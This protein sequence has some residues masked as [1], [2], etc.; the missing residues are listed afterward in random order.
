MSVINEINNNHSVI[1]DMKILAKYFFKERAE[2]LKDL[3][4]EFISTKDIIVGDEFL[5]VTSIIHKCIN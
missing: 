3:D 1:H 2:E 5:V 4:N